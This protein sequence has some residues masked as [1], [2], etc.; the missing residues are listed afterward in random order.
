MSTRVLKFVAVFAVLIGATAATFNSE[1]SRHFEILKN[2]EIFTNLYREVNSNY[3]DDIDPGEF[4][5]TG[6]DAMVKS[7]DPYTNYISEADI[8]GYRFITEGKYHGIGAQ[9]TII[10]DYV[11]I[12]ELYKDQPADKAGLRPGD[13]VIAV[14]GQN[15][16]G[17]SM[18]D[19]NQIIRG[20]PGSTVVLTVKR[21]GER[22]E[23]TF[24]VVRENIEV[25]NV[26]YYGMVS[27]EVGY[28]ILTKFTR[29][30]SRNIAAAFKDLKKENPNMSGI[31][32]DL[33]NNGGGLLHEA[34]NICNIFI[35]KDELVVSTKGK[36]KDW[37]RNFNTSGTPIDLDIPIAVLING[38]SASASEIVSGVLQDY[39]RG[40]LIGQQSYGKGLVQNTMDLGYNAKVKVTTA[41]YYIPS[42]RCIQAVDYKDGKPVSI[43]DAERTKFHTKNGRVVLDGG[44]V[45]PDIPVDAPASSGIL[46]SLVDEHLIFQFLNEYCKNV[47]SIDKVEKYHFT[48]FNAFV[49]FLERKDFE[50]ESESDDLINKLIST[51]E[52][53]GYQLS[54]SLQQLKAEM[55]AAKKAEV[56]KYK[57]Q[58]IKLIEKDMAA[59]YYYQNGKI[60]MGLRNDDEIKVAI[61]ILGNEK[62]Y[63]KTLGF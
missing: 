41:K 11:T 8:E 52:E 42:Q 53:E 38:R 36:V 50:F 60:E 54:S 57:T 34:V 14:D 46:K 23:Q 26:P 39:D 47:P 6:I 44:G 45:R 35:P 40:V 20:A 17:K 4:M 27:D 13:Q 15:A 51:S 3:V 61:D 58:I 22:N 62:E 32:L 30:A 19:F 59:R 12:T 55:K 63:K 10:D 56:L 7:L 31:I 24:N 28:I 25:K 43:P 18:S 16:K 9:S 5:R 1:D 2:I 33:R 48:D 29:E 21:P 37:G 49:D